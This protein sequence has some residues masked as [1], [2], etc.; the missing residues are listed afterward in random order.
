M[1]MLGADNVL[2]SNN[3]P[4]LTLKGL[5]AIH[6]LDGD[7]LE[8]EFA[9]QDIF[10]IFLLVE[11][12]PVMIPRS[13]IR[14]IVGR[15]EQAI[16]VDTS[17]FG[18]KAVAQPHPVEQEAVLIPEAEIF[19]PEIFNPELFDEAAFDEEEDTMILASDQVQFDEIEDQFEDEDS[20][21]IIPLDDEDVDIKEDSGTIILTTTLDDMD[22]TDTTLVVDIDTMTVL[23]EDE[24]DATVVLGQES[25]R[26]ELS[27]SLICTSGPHTGEMVKLKSGIT[28]IGRSSDNVI[29]LNKDKE[30]SRHHAIVLQE[31]GRF[32]VQDQNSLNGT[33]V[34]DEQVTGARYLEDGDVILVGVSTFRYQEE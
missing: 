18:S 1:L 17:S 30:I 14:Y 34:N 10:N 26:S 28:T 22:E 12:E 15:Q 16:E 24:D 4:L 31:S 11:G 32:V 3:L 5:V 2:Y 7:V 8:G 6:F 25:K 33:F 27:A 9:S 20:T 21:V 19:D 29:V 23:E 13:Q